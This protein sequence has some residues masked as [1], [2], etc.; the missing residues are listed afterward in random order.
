MIAQC[1]NAVSR[2]LSSKHVL[3]WLTLAVTTLVFTLFIYPSLVIKTP[4]YKLGDVVERDVKASKEFF[5]EDTDAT[6]ANRR[7]AAASVLTVY[8]MDENL[9]AEVQRRVALA[10]ENIRA[11]ASAPAPRPA[12]ATGPSMLSPE[13]ASRQSAARQ[14]IWEMK[15]DFEKLL[16]IP[17][18]SGAFQV[19]EDEGF[20]RRIPELIN[21]ILGEIMA[22]GVVEN[23]EALL[24]DLEKG[25]VLRNPTTGSEKTERNLKR[26]YGL[27]QAKTM[28][29]I[30]GQPILA[31][32]NYSLRNLIVDFAQRLIQPSIT[33][34]RSETGDR[35]KRAVAQVKPVLYKIKAGEMLLREGERVN[36]KQLGK[37]KDLQTQTERQNFVT[38]GLGAAMI[39]L[40]FLL[41][42]YN[43]HL[44][45]TS[46]QPREHNRNIL[47]LASVLVSFLFF[48]R[49]LALMPE[50]GTAPLPLSISASSTYFV[51]PLAAGAMTIC[52]FLGAEIALPFTLVMSVFAA[53]IFANRLEVFIYFLLSGFMAA[54]WMRDCKER[55]VFIKTGL[56]IGLL[57]MGLAF[58]IGIYTGA[59]LSGKLAWDMTFG[60]LGGIFAGIITAGVAPLV[61]WVFGFTTDI[62]LLEL[63]NLDQPILRR[64]MIEAPGT[65]NHSVI[66]GTMAEAAAAEVSANLLLAKVCGYYHDIGKIKQPLYFIENQ[67]GG[68]NRHDKLAPS[69]SGLVI[70]SHV[71][72]GVEMAK[73]CKLGQEIVDTIQQHHG[74]SLITFFYEKAKQLKGKDSVKSSD[75]RYPGP[76][77]QTRETA[78]VMLADVVEAASRTL[79][80]PTSS[81]IQGLVQNLVNKVFSDGQ[82]NECE[83]TLKDLNN[84]A[85]SFNKILN[86]IYHHR[87][88]YPESGA[89]ANGK[90]KNGSSGRQP[91]GE[92][93]D[94]AQD[95]RA[96][97]ENHL[98]RLGI[99]G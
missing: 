17:A 78:I 46:K 75:F 6:A 29:R 93:S 83:L 21:R 28:V 85:K 63:A 92:P 16:G 91:A 22:N 98:K 37:L 52:L 8:D 72:A 67:A 80:N 76:K 99:R 15:G 59:P 48:T 18:S 62:K 41:A 94:N 69:M 40:S 36:V 9:I 20:S 14:R 53:A 89:A 49:V 39:I 87:I 35:E 44:R 32:I 54:H 1:K 60:F 81:R 12:D 71:K 11:V 7:E 42:T 19:L 47:F 3:R 88:E 73:K 66:V 74:T 56:K 10:F 13:G 77:P 68:K 33:E 4:A 55:K 34:S 95:D 26:F 30:V 86:G 97:S 25:I 45:Q 27:D 79:E 2:F 70:I 23:K 51:I 82:L 65:Y 57:N 43:L 64:L 31:D 61:E 24:G 50:W 90:G 5:I 96:K 38:T 58:A 84:I